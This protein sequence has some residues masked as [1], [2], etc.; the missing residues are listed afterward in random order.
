L[1]IK[2]I[3]TLTEQFHSLSEKALPFLL[4]HKVVLQRRSPQM[5]PLLTGTI[6]MVSLEVLKGIEPVLRPFFG[7]KVAAQEVIEPVFQF[8]LESS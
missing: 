8:S 5:Q 4:S 2:A 1:C 7:R 6:S 3:A